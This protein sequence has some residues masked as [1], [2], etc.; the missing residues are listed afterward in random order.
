MKDL[1]DQ[2]Q[3]L[4]I[5]KL[6]LIKSRKVARALFSSGRRP[7]EAPPRILGLLWAVSYEIVELLDPGYSQ[8]RAANRGS[9]S[10]R[11]PTNR[12][13]ARNRYQRSTRQLLSLDIRSA[14][15]VD[16]AHIE[17]GRRVQP[18]ELCAAN[19]NTHQAVLKGSLCPPVVFGI[20]AVH[21]APRVGRLHRETTEFNTV[22]S[23]KRVLGLPMQRLVERRMNR[24]EA[25][26][27]A[28]PIEERR[29]IYELLYQACLRAKAGDFFQSPIE[30]TATSGTEHRNGVVEL[31]DQ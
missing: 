9:Q 4:S 29:R 20:V 19:V 2:T 15:L 30:A 11:H 23:V 31:D 27:E 17:F 26:I 10:T 18:Q 3:D 28:L 22:P 16:G 14:A 21:Q 25:V 8:A 12:D 7:A 5:L 1:R 6:K 13:R 24:C